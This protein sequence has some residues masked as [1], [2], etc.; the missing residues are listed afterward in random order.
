MSKIKILKSN[1]LLTSN[2]LGKINGGTCSDSNSLVKYKFESCT[3][4]GSYTS[5]TI[6]ENKLCAIQFLTCHGG[7]NAYQNCSGTGG[8]GDFLQCGQYCYHY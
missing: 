7:E 6:Y 1:R 3:V 5:C 4:G 2:S 8:V